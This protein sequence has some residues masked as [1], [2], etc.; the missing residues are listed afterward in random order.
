MTALV[1]DVSRCARK[2]AIRK[3]TLAMSLRMRRMLEAPHEGAE[4]Y[5]SAHPSSVFGP[6]QSVCRVAEIAGE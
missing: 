4:S 1:P 6:L 3:N 2:P 5:Q